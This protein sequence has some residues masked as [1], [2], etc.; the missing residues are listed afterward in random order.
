M[1]AD[2]LPEAPSHVEVPRA[3]ASLEAS[4]ATRLPPPPHQI[5][6]RGRRW[7]QE[8]PPPMQTEAQAAPQAAARVR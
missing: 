7:S 5:P 4:T 6:C 3:V 1:A 2:A 8:Q